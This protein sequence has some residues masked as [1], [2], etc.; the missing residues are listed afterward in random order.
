MKS[1]S[2]P[3]AILVITM[4]ALI[5]CSSAVEESKTDEATTS[6]QKMEEVQKLPSFT[7]LDANGNRVNLASFV[8]KKVFVNLWATWCP[9]CRHEIPSIEKLYK[10]ADKEKAVFVLLS[11]DEHFDEAKQFA[12][13]NKLRVPVF[14]PAEKLPD[15]FNVDAIPATYIFNEQGELV[16][17]IKSMDDYYTKEYIELFK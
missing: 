4:I 6:P 1:F 3:I 16:K 13:K 12:T 10:G 17:E 2:I 14:Y 7:M 5:A 8:G 9:P 11:L 15:L